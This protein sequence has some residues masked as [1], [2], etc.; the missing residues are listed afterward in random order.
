M[1]W[2]HA[3]PKAGRCE[4]QHLSCFRGRRKTMYPPEE[5]QIAM[6]TTA[7]W[8]CRIVNMP[9]CPFSKAQGIGVLL[10]MSHVLGLK[11]PLSRSIHHILMPPLAASKSGSPPW[12][13]SVPGL[14]SFHP[15]SSSPA[16]VN[17]IPAAIVRGVWSA[18]PWMSGLDSSP[19]VLAPSGLRGV[20]P[21]AFY[22]LDLISH[23]GTPDTTDENS[24]L[25]RGW[26]KV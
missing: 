17:P 3:L 18:Y 12:H 9:S 2:S 6:A 26:I 5:G 1:R 11:P 24:S 19:W 7:P 10:W 8:S 4:V 16:Q 25:P 13:H 20:C 21:H 22:S 14:T 15:S 23:R